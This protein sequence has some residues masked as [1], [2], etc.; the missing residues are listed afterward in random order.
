MKGAPYNTNTTVSQNRISTHTVPG[1]IYHLYERES[2]QH[3]LSMLS[4][5]VRRNWFSSAPDQ[6]LNFEYISG[7]CLLRMQEWGPSLTHKYQG[8]YRLEMD[9]SWTPME[10]IR[11]MSMKNAWAHRILDSTTIN[12]S[13]FLAID[14][15]NDKSGWI[16][17]T[18]INS[19]LKIR[20]T[21]RNN[22][23]NSVSI[24]INVICGIQPILFIY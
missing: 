4:P 22:F 2:G 8:S 20:S 23:F 5:E 14:Q 18:A 11:E 9:Q 19:S 21:D 10:K 15:V 12:S 13:S 17:R 7:F 3:Y 16:Y 24:D 1:N 6:R